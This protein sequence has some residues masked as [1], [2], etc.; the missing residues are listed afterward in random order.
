MLVQRRFPPRGPLQQG[1]GT[2]PLGD[3][4]NAEFPVTVIQGVGVKFVDSDSGPGAGGSF[5]CRGLV[6]VTGGGHCRY[7]CGV[8]RA[9]AGVFRIGV[10]GY[11][12]LGG[13]LE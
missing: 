12:A 4:F 9:G 13:G 6:G 11:G 5:G 3:G 2:L 7:I 8:L 10:G 1:L